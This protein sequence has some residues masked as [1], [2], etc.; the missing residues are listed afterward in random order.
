MLELRDGNTRDSEHT[1]V[2][3]PVTQRRKQKGKMKHYCV[4]PACASK[5]S[6]SAVNIIVGKVYE[7]RNILSNNTSIEVK[8]DALRLGLQYILVRRLGCAIPSSAAGCELVYV[9]TDG[10]I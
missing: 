1:R 10:F 6:S 5:R 3:Y 2:T 9:H 4:L 7:V 8:G